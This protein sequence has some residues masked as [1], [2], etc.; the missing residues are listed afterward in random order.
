MNFFLINLFI[1]I[2]TCQALSQSID[3]DYD[4]ELRYQND[5][6][7]NLKSELKELRLKI[8]TTESRERS[9]VNR[10]SSIDKE[11]S[12]TGKLI[13][14]LKYEEERA[15]KTIYQLKNDILAKEN[16]LES[17]RI[18]YKQR[19]LRAYKKGRLT[20]LE[21]V[22]SSTTW[23]QAVYRTHYLK[24]IAGIEKK[25]T[26]K[27]EKILVEISRQKV[28]LEVALRDNLNLKRDKESQIS[29]YRN[30][31][32]N[33]EKELNRIRNDKQALTSYVT[34]KE[35]GVE[36]L[37]KIIKRVLEDKARFERELRIRQQQEILKTK[38]FKALKGQLPWPAD[39]RIVS[40]F[41]RQWNP[42]LKTTTENP[43]VDIKGKP[44]SSIRS[45]LGG[46]VTTIT[47]I[48]GYGTTIII[49]HGGGFYTVYSHVTNI[50]INVDSQVRNGDVIA[51]MGDS[52]SVNGTK[53]H[54]EI[55]GKGQKLDPE[56]WL[57]KR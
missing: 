35:E 38:S 54:F 4:G 22:F 14:S 10:L 36:Q 39:G 11:I 28:E 32:I 47:Y 53:L 17:L 5:A 34:E 13:Q 51:Y 27:I 26:K 23:R 57:I 7:N 21:R 46:V 19:V 55:W 49:D 37:E 31:R 8:K 56:K 3:R 44:G 1:A 16:E 52:G 24:I 20:D 15:R 9:T 42:K 2:F 50:Q 29:S 30:M 48:R 12:L 40:K 43:G 25:I 33:R 41:G 6:I 45:I 18:R